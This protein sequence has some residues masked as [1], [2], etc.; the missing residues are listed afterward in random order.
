MKRRT[1]TRIVPA[2]TTTPPAPITL[3]AR[4]KNNQ[5]SDQAVYEFVSWLTRFPD[6]DE[7]LRKSGLTRASLRALESDDEIAQ[8]LDTRRDALLATPWRLEPQQP[9]ANKWLAE[10]LT[11]HMHD[12]ICCAFNAVIYGY[13]V[14]EVVYV[15][16]AS[17]IGISHLGEKPLEWFEP[18]H[19]G[20]LIYRPMV[21]GEIV[22][23]TRKYLLSRSRPTYLQPYGESLLSRLYWPAFFRSHGRKFWA[24]FLER[25]GE[26]LLI[27]KVRDQQKFV[28]DLLALGVGAG[29][30]VGN[31][32][33][34]DHIAVTQAGEFER[35]EQAMSKSI[36][37][38]ILGQ[39]LTSDVGKTG[40]Y[41]AAKVH[42]QV[43]ETKRN[44]DIRLVTKAA[45][46][47]VN[48]LC[49]LNG[50][51]NPPEFVMADD[52]GLEIDRA[53]RD[54]IHFDLG[55]RHTPEYFMDRYDYREG[56]FEMA[57]DN[58]PA[59]PQQ[60]QQQQA[61]EDPQT[62]EEIDKQ[63]AA[64]AEMAAH[65]LHMR[66]SKVRFTPQQQAIEDAG[67][68]IIAKAPQPI[69]ADAMLAAVKAAADPADLAVRLSL[70]LDK[71]D[72]RFAELLARSNF[73]AQVLG[74]VVAEKEA[75]QPAKQKD[76]APPQIV[77]HFHM[78][79]TFG[80]PA[81]ITVNLPA[82]EAPPAPHAHA[83]TVSRT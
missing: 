34:I 27:G 73:A 79:D 57:E 45:Q 26:P 14:C 6:P 55:I 83:N 81:P 63:D 8:C 39:T 60:Q 78:P 53:K 68:A 28:S 12:L 1:S 56:D 5:Y 74:Y 2:T 32:D 54:K 75:P 70:L 13:S 43:K 82:Q 48:I 77:Q 33:S 18:R 24:K 58:P 44:A 50:I 41:A 36:Q 17:K 47:L 38:M 3:A 35:F 80:A 20:E 76:E 46:S 10:E 49:D 40:S 21:G 15:P 37:K 66:K 71:Q 52:T 23:D 31:E 69:P 42:D 65:L 51:S 16:R 67:S 61:S 7:V 4:N 9:R 25:F 11:P 72:P 62:P 30:P 22:C 64:D 29:L 59:V 19:N